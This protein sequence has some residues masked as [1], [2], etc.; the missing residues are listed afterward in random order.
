MKQVL[1]FVVE[2]T[3]TPD[4]SRD[5]GQNLFKCLTEKYESDSDAAKLM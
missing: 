1:A 2:L 4:S 5:S 3:Q